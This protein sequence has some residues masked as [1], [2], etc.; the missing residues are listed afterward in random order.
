[1]DEGQGTDD[2]VM[3]LRPLTQSVKMGK[4]RKKLLAK[5]TMPAEEKTT[6]LI[7]AHVKSIFILIAWRNIFCISEK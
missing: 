5:I 1:M 3:R 2:Q 4:N 6:F 7:T